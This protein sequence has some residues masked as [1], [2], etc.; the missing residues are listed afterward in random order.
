MEQIQGF[1]KNLA[2]NL[3]RLSSTIIKTRISTPFDK[4]EYLANERAIVNFPNRMFDCRS[5][6][7]T[8]KCIS[9]SNCHFSR[10]GL[11]TLI[12]NLQITLNSRPVQST[13]YY[14]YI[15][16]ALADVSGYYSPEQECKRLYENFNPSIAHTNQIGEA[17]PALSLNTTS[18]T[19]ETKFFS[20]NNFIGFFSCSAS[21]LDL[22]NLGN[23]QLVITL[24]PDTVQWIGQGTTAAAPNAI[25]PYKVQQLTLWMD[26]ITFTSSL[27]Q[28]LIKSQLEGNG[29]NIAYH[30]Y[31][32]SVNPLVSKSASGIT[33][34]AQFN[35]NSL[36]AVYAV[37]RPELFANINPLCLGDAIINTSNGGNCKGSTTYYEQ[38]ISVP[39]TNAGTCGGF[40]QSRYFQRDG[41][42]ITSSSWYVNS[43]PLVIND[44]NIAIF[45]N[46]LNCLDYAGVDIASGG[47]HKGALTTGFY[48]KF[49]MMDALSLENISGDG[50]NWVSGLSSSGTI[51]NIS[52]TARFDT[53]TNKVYPYIIGKVSKIMNVKIGRNIDIME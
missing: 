42:G 52:Y 34:V 48:N 23:L 12:E 40:N 10:G 47:F 26:A 27:Y 45:N 44:T 39:V 2:Y 19:A 16:Q 20:V 24:A 53:N 15:F 51:I 37:F 28:D 9:G 7:L 31:L 22:N 30:D 25:N 3:K 18:T 11:N 17:D 14:N 46:L 43:Q 29:L 4:N 6:S 36:D 50:N 49:Y 8:A 1:P 35:T 38:V 32:V 41:G 33:A 5:V 13:P 21:T